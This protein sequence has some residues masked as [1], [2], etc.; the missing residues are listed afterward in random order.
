MLKVGVDIIKDKKKGKQRKFSY[1]DVEYDCDD[2]ADAAK[3]LPADYDL[4]HLKT[5]K[6]TISGWRSGNVWAG[7]RLKGDEKFLYWK[8]QS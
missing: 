5:E 6:K 1:T 7:L 8:R 4:V 2:W 3:Y